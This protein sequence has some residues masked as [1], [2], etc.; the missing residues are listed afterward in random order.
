MEH[1]PA[2]KELRSKE[3]I[4]SN[5]NRDAYQA[6]INRQMGNDWLDLE[7]HVAWHGG[8]VL[9]GVV[10]KRNEGGWLLI[11]KAH[12]N[13]RAYASYIQCASL[14]ECFE[15]GGEFAARGIFTWQEDQWPSKWL[16]ARLG[17]NK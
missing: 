4:A 3:R 16:K 14:S 17:I 9:N 2:D 10:T 6:L 13:G 7:K 12:R 15:L 11:L 1:L 5:T 8:Y